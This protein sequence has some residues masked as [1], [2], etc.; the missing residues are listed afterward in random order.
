MR[1]AISNIFPCFEELISKKKEQKSLELKYISKLSKISLL[2][3]LQ[4]RPVTC[5]GHHGERR[6]F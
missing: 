4:G 3:L 2:I 5:L 1:A 6:V